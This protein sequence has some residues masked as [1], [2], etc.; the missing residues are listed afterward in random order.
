MKVTK[1]YIKRL[2]REELSR[3]LSVNEVFTPVEKYEG[4]SEEDFKM[5]RKSTRG[6]DQRKNER[7]SNLSGYKM[8]EAARYAFQLAL[9]AGAVLGFS[10]GDSSQGSAD[11]D[12]NNAGDKARIS[13]QMGGDTVLT[14]EEPV[15]N[16]RVLGVVASTFKKGMQEKM[17]EIMGSN[18]RFAIRFVNS[19]GY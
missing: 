13:V 12:L 5:R 11:T 10:T 2:I 9:E 3:V 8:S 16:E 1:S 19:L 18:P 14:I 17:E 6:R 4:E 7:E 15:E